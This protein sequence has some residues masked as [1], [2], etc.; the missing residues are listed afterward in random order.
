MDGPSIVST[1]MLP[2]DQVI[3]FFDGKFNLS[4]IIKVD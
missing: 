1:G 3:N 4:G 2:F